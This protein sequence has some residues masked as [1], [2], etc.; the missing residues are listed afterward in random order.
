MRLGSLTAQ[1]KLMSNLF[2]F[3]FFVGILALAL[4][5]GKTLRECMRLYFKLKDEVFVGHRPYSS[6]KFEGI[7]KDTFGETATMAD[8]ASPK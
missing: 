2:M 3:I 4:A 5:S 8:I 7:L 1:V 6:E